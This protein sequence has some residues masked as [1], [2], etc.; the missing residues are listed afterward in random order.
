M[1]FPWVAHCVRWFPAGAG[2]HL[3]P[4]TKEG[5]LQKREKR[6]DIAT[7]LLG[8]PSIELQIQNRA[9]GLV[10]GKSFQIAETF[11]PRRKID[12]N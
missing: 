3:R 4:K 11:R 9:P 8:S 1:P 12:R 5:G 6:D 10:N 7:L 2:D